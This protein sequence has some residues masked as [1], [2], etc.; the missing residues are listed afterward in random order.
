MSTSPP[1]E[2]NEPSL[3][4]GLLACAPLFAFYEIGLLLAGDD[5][6]RH[7]A[8]R[9]LGLLFS[10][11]GSFERGLRWVMLA[12]LLA[13]ASARALRSEVPLRR[14]F[15]RILL[16]GAVAAIALGPLLLALVS[17]FDPARFDWELPAGPTPLAPS[18]AEAC[19][20]AGAAAWEELLFR[21]ACYGLVFLLASRVVQFFG[22]GRT[23]AYLM[24]EWTAI[25]GSSVLFS[26][27]HLSSFQRL[28]GHQG[29]PFDAAIFLWRLL[30]GL[31]L[32]GLFR[33]RGLG[34]CA[35]AH[36]LFNLGLVLGAGPGVFQS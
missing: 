32:A 3:S 23:V 20:L 2:V 5:S 6:K 7:G 18:L 36:A 15:V 1:E 25:V 9:T 11:F 12:V 13:W 31:L 30:A 22:V 27:F 16:E 28:I 19:R 24:G 35:W 29:E 34:V 14:S 21:V 26:A 33:W 4:L 17:F 10:H 8:E